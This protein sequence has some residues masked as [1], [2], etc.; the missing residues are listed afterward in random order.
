MNE[1]K[2][3][4]ILINDSKK[5]I[6][7]NILIFLHEIIKFIFIKSDNQSLL[8]KE[9][10]KLDDMISKINKKIIKNKDKYINKEYTI[11]NFKNILNF[12][13]MQNEMCAG[14]ILENILIKIFSL[15]YKNENINGFEKYIYSNNLSEIE[16]QKFIDFLTICFK[17][18]KFKQEELQNL[19]GILIIEQIA[20]TNFTKYEDLK[21]YV[22]YN[23][24]TEIYK[25]KYKDNINLNRNKSHKA[26]NYIQKMNYET[27][28]DNFS[29]IS[30]PSDFSLIQSEDYS[31]DYILDSTFIPNL[32][33]INSDISEPIII[34]PIFKSFL[35]Q[36]F[37]Y[38]QNKNSSFVGST[39]LSDNESED[40]LPKIYNLN[41]AKIIGNNG[42]TILT[43]LR[44]EPKMYH[45]ILTDNKL[46]E[47]GLM[48]MS[49][50]IFFNNNIKIID[51]DYS[52]VKSLQMYYFNLGLGLFD[53]YSVE[54]LN[55]SFNDLKENCKEY[56]GRLISHLK[57]LKTI[58]L[59][60]NKFKGGLSFFFVLLKK[61]YRKGKTKLENLYLSNCQLD[62]TSLYE[63]G[64]LLK[65]KYCKLKK[66]FL[67]DNI[68]PL[69]Y[70]NFLKIIKKNKSLVEIHLGV[71]DI[72][73]ND[74]DDINR[75]ISYTEIR[76][77]YLYRNKITNFNKLLKIIYRTKLVK[78][79]TN[80]TNII[81]N[82]SC[83]I[84]LDLS[85]NNIL[86]KNADHINLIMKI[87]DETNLICLD[88]SQII[89]KENNLNNEY[90]IKIDELV[91]TLKE[92]KKRNIKK[93]K[94]LESN[95]VDLERFKN[96]E[97][98]IYF[99]VLDK[100]IIQ[101]IKNKKSK[102][103][104]FLKVEAKKLIT[105]NKHIFKNIYINEIIDDEKYIK[106]EEQLVEYMMKKRVEEDSKIIE[107]E[108]K[109]QKLIIV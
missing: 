102:Y 77:L 43:P 54:D 83:L 22:I 7:E 75:I 46:N 94:N 36:V 104:V 25:S 66:L 6:N 44:I 78:E 109:N 89:N 107:E 58:N 100:E 48:E 38:D 1:R 62:S 49:K 10:K 95:K 19:K 14:E 27:Y 96:S 9:E 64:E 80:D 26:F 51:Y 76:H 31:D 85:N 106:I 99:K 86:I 16:N 60:S 23:I 105:N 13:K 101:I 4:K 45:I 11:K 97:N 73:N 69:F 2:N 57:G 53:N 3:Y 20:K 24:L 21:T 33:F 63:L 108:I 72:N 41:G 52:S 12:I 55:L 90:T 88:I 87:I 18:D 61:L 68:I 92:N 84:N 39:N 35:I 59:S 70:K 37:I 71:F 8:F 67:S 81:K 40:E 65:S 74:I 82:D 56:L 93:I 34:F 17:S 47:L 42:T 30:T 79:K 98:E 29:S 50:V 103:P 91:S 15:T 32:Y 5:M 28:P